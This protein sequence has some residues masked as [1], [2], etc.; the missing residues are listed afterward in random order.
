MV[1]LPV[2]MFRGTILMDPPVHLNVLQKGIV[3]FDSKDTFGHVLN[4]IVVTSIVCG[5]NAK[6]F[7][8]TFA[9]VS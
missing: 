2:Q 1:F 6:L 8:R 3:S 5:C 7:S 9:F 4:K